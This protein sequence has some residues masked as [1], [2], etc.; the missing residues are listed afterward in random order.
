MNCP[1]CGHDLTKC[2]VCGGQLQLIIY[3][4]IPPQ[5]AVKCFG[6]GYE[7]KRDK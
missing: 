5:S 4:V 7:E 1:K 3:P 6:C 2:P